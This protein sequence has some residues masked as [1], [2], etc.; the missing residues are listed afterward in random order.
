MTKDLFG[1]K[2]VKAKEMASIEKSSFA[3]D[4]QK[5]KTFMLNAG[6]SIARA[7]EAFEKKEGLEKKVL[8]LIGKGNNGGDAFVAGS[9]LLKRGFTVFAVTTH[10]LDQCS[11]LCQKMAKAFLKQEGT[12]IP[13]DQW[14]NGEVPSPKTIIV[15]GLLGTGF[16]GELKE[17]FLSLI[18]KVNL[19]KNPVIAIDIP[20]GVD[21]NTGQ[22]LTEAITA[23]LTVFLGMA[24]TGFFLKEGYS[25]VQHLCYGDFGLEQDYIDKANAD[26]YLVDE[27][28]LIKHLPEI[29]FTRHKYQAG[30]LLALS[31]SSGMR[32]A[33]CLSS[34]AALR[35]GCGMV[36]LFVDKHLQLHLPVEVV[37]SDL[38]LENILQEA[39]RAKAMYIG[40][41]IGRSEDTLSLLKDLLPKISVPLLLDA[42]ALYLIGQNK[43]KVPKDAI[44]T[45]HRKEMCYLLG[46]E[47]IDQDEL[48]FFK[49]CQDYAN[50]NEINLVLKGAPTIIFAKDNPPLIIPHGD[51]GMATA[52]TGDVLTGII[53]SYLAQGVLPYIAS[54]LGVYIHGLCGEL[55][56]RQKTSYGVI[57]SDLI[58]AITP[59]LKKIK[60]E[61]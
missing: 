40:P 6:A 5:E 31:G 7:I 2:V 10:S 50:Q 39:K 61:E 47:K 16:K 13:L 8:L 36:R 55:S 58:E 42:D 21:G 1:I 15:D 28:N 25:H 12:I 59:V 27:K 43:L 35:T 3:N 49:K 60:D 34:L 24:K 57:A 19:L 20:T 41:G 45:P 18:K 4:S 52:G 9:L 48:L 51:P 14:L 33:A 11:P 56:G 32:G 29:T 23:N 44:L 30:Y 38:S 54:C 53:S 17:P 22:V 37:C 46:Q 26:F